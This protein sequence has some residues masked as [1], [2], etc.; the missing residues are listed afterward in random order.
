MH[1]ALC[2]PC[3]LVMEYVDG[4]PLIVDGEPA[5]PLAQGQHLLRA[6]L[7]EYG[8]Q[9]FLQVCMPICISCALIATTSVC[10]SLLWVVGQTL[11]APPLTLHRGGR[12]NVLLDPSVQ[13]ESRAL[14]MRC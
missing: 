3:V 10:V 4:T 9:V 8:R 6:L 14:R 13:L 12:V 2:T 11:L 5:V 1:E 7:F